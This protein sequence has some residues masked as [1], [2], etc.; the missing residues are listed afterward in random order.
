MFQRFDDPWS[1][2]PG[3]VLRGYDVAQI[4]LNGH[5]INDRSA[6]QPEHNS[7]H[8]DKCG[9]ETITQCPKCKTDIRGYYHVP[10]VVSL[11]GPDPAPAFCPKCGTAHPWTE[12]RLI[13]AREYVRELDRLT[14]NEKGVLSR[15]LDDLV[16]DTPNSPVAAL[17]FKQLVTKAG[18]AALDGLKTILVQVITESA[19]RQI[20]PQ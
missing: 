10:N 6:S 9:A 4:C 5:V 18:S 3:T 17:R 16:R 13:A 2:T 12:S 19:K 8:C 7:P 20:W 15:S 14:D 11:T 1:E